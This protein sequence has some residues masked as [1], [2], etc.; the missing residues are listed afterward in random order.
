MSRWRDIARS[1]NS[2]AALVVALYIPV[3][4]LVHRVPPPV[5]LPTPEEIGA[6]ARAGGYRLI[7]LEALRGR[8]EREAGRLLLVDT[9]QDWEYRS[10]HI[11]GAVSFPVEPTWWSRLKSR[12]G[13]REALG[14]DKARPVVFY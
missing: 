6:E 13:L 7:G 11:P 12:G 3:L 4:L 14:A 8:L 5:A 1:G 10:G 9:R 2:W